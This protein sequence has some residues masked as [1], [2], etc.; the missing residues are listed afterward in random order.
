MVPLDAIDNI[1]Y[2]KGFELEEGRALDIVGDCQNLDNAR[3]ISDHLPVSA[4]FL[5]K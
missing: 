2:S 1:Y 3:R 5:V 4:M